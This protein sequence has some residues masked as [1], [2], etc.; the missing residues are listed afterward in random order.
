[1]STHKTI[2]FGTPKFAVPSLQ[3]LIETGFSVEAVVT[4]PD[5]PTGRKGA[6]TPPPVKVF[7]QE[8]GLKVLQPLTLK[9]DSFFEEFT[10]INPDICIVVAYGKIIHQRYLD[11][12]KYGFVNIHP[13]LLPRYRG[14]SPIQSAIL[15]GDPET[16]VTLMRIDEEMDHGPILKQIEYQISKEK[17][18]E[19]IEKEL[20]EIGAQILV[21]TLPDYLNEKITSREQDHNRATFCKK[22]ERPDGRIDWS[23]PAEKIYNQIRALNPNPGVWTTL[24]D[25]TLNIFDAEIVDFN[26]QDKVIKEKSRF[27]IRASDKYISPTLLQLE[28]KKILP[29][30]DFLNGLRKKTLIIK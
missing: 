22:Y 8:K 15:N 1:M 12:P 6:S 4:T 2:L 23:K 28:G 3:K 11:I 14:P 24:N 20:A 17:K 7:A 29:I 30:K 10:K 26:S 5:E 25:K 21:D 27:L 16:G 9:D 18:Y 19:E 13:S